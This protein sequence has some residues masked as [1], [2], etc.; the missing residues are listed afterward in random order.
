M[1]TG[2]EHVAITSNNTKKLADW[3]VETLGF[4][5][6]YTGSKTPPTYFVKAPN[7]ALIELMPAP[8]PDKPVNEMDTHGY[9]HIALSTDDFDGDRERLKSLGVEQVGEPKAGAG[10]VSVAFMK[11]PEGNIFQLIN[12]INPL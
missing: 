1:L 4:K 10:G 8:D 9:H 11:D 6:V 2:I 5:I 7:G 12:R 3:Y